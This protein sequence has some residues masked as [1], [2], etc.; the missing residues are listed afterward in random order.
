MN[1]ANWEVWDI[2]VQLLL[3]LF[4]LW[5]M[6]LLCDPAETEIAY[7]SCLLNFKNTHKQSEVFGEKK[8]FA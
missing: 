8:L 2:L 1:K 7:L 3:K 5:N 4:G 6:Q